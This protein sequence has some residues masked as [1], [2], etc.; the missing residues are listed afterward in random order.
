[1]TNHRSKTPASWSRRRLLTVALAIGT[2]SALTKNAAAATAKALNRDA[3]SALKR[4]AAQGPKVQAL[5]RKAVGILIFPKIVKG[6]LIIGGQS[7]DG[8]L[9]I[10]GKTAGY[11]NIAAGSIGLQVG[12]Q[13]FS[14]ALLFMHKDALDYLRKSDGWLIWQRL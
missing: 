13:S 6:G 1:M 9:R 10:G 4:L 14:Y 11:Y 2:V 12:G 3:D 8:V 5:M 7:G